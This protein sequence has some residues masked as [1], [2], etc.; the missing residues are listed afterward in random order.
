MP[1]FSQSEYVLK[2]P[3]SECSFSDH[4]S[5]IVILKRPGNDLCG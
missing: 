5:P 3:F 2:N 4:K 1:F